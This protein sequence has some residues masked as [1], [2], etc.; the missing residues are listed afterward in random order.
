[1]IDVRPLDVAG[2]VLRM[3]IGPRITRGHRRRLLCRMLV[4]RWFCGLVA[5]NLLVLMGVLLDRL[6]PG[7]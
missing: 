4:G 2:T 3:T 6:P 7:P 1:M 5:S